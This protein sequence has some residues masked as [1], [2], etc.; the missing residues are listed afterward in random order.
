VRESSKKSE[1]KCAPGKASPRT[2]SRQA[3]ILARLSV[4]AVLGR[5]SRL[6]GEI[7][8]ALDGGVPAE[9]IHE[10]F[11]QLYLFAGYPRMINAFM[12]LE[13]LDPE[14]LRR[15]EE[16][17][18]DAFE[19]GEKLCRAIYRRHFDPMIARMR[20]MHPDLGRWILSEGYGKVLG[21]PWLDGRTRELITVA[22][23]TAQGLDKQ[24][25][26]H[27]RGA[28]NLGAAPRDVEE[29]LDAV[30]DLVPAKR[31]ERCRAMLK[32]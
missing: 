7:R 16:S 13:G 17:V 9:K 11:L 31:I 26:F 22:V 5:E 3:A 28:Q 1:R 6:R 12:A 15:V 18:P 27:V 24:L 19:R 4:L 23:L 10:S 2:S 32:T 8:R 20:S 29:V 21:R 14:V 25:Y 30:A